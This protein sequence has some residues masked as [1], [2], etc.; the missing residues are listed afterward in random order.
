M[1]AFFRQEK[2]WRTAF[3]Q[4]YSLVP[5][6]SVAAWRCRDLGRLEFGQALW[7]YGSASVL[8]GTLVV[9]YAVLFLSVDTG[10]HCSYGWLWP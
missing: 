7:F 3:L 10:P 4:A 6:S 9:F 2:C 5:C 1:N 8:W